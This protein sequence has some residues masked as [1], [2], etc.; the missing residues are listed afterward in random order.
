MPQNSI[1]PPNIILLL[2]LPRPL[3]NLSHPA[4]FQQYKSKIHP[5]A[6]R[7]P[8][9]GSLAYMQF[10]CNFFQSKILSRFLITMVM[11]DMERDVSPVLNNDDSYTLCG[12]FFLFLPAFES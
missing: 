10:R 12:E 2:D 1:T 3:P 11:I 6:T 7:I 8:N 4:P 5:I 9:R